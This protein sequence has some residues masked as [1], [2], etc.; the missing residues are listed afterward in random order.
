MCEKADYW[1][2]TVERE[3]NLVE[4]EMKIFLLCI[5]TVFLIIELLHPPTEILKDRKESVHNFT[6]LKSQGCYEN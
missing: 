1:D 4:R 6:Y 5:Y 2:K 3:T